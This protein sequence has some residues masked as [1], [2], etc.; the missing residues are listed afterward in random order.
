MSEDVSPQIFERIRTVVL[1]LLEDISIAESNCPT[2]A[3]VAVLSYSSDTKYLI[4][5]SDYHRKH[6][7]MKAVKNIA[8]KRTS[9]RRNIGAAMRFVARNVFKRVRQG[10]L[11]RKVAVFITNGPS[12]DMTPITTAML[13]FKAL[14]IS[15]AVLA[16]RNPPNVRRAFEADESGNF[17]LTVMRRPQDLGPD[18]RQ[19][20]QC[21]ICYDP[22]SPAEACR[23]ISLVP[24]PLE[25]DVD[26]ALVLDS[27]RN[28]RSDQF[29]GMRQVLGSVLD[30]IV[31]STQ[32]G[33]PNNQARVALVQHSTSSYPPREGQDLAK[34]EFDLVGYKDRNEMKKHIFQLMKQIGGASGLGHAIE[35]TIQNMMLKAANPHKNQDCPGHRWRRD[36]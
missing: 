34:V 36:Q 18:L 9:D 35:W 33:R 2:G 14:D 16:F 27:S 30:Q 6:S 13:E 8:L 25:L 22:C 11:M 21:V 29:E 24:V 23:G 3:R 17:L 15:P 31:V 4:R 5:F 32:P 28:I 20:Q 7:L 10:V 26:L 1:T 19:V 12:Q